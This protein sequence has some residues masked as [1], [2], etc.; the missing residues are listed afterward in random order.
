MLGTIEHAAV[1]VALAAEV[2]EHMHVCTDK[3]GKRALSGFTDATDLAEQ[4]AVVSGADYRS[5]HRV[6]GALASKAEA[7][8][9]DRFSEADL[10]ELNLADRPPREPA[11]SVAARNVPGG[12]DPG[13]VRRQAR[14]LLRRTTARRQW[15]EEQSALAVTTR[16][17]LLAEAAAAAGP[18]SAGSAAAG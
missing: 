10:L 1:L 9:R 13:E 17:N 12:A 18:S 5:A 7:E 14:R 8:G 6:V 2:V 16:A 4:L 15:R 3:L 11:A